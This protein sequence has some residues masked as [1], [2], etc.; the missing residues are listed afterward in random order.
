MARVYHLDCG[1]MRPR[2]APLV[3]GHGR[4][5]DPGQLVCHVMLVEGN[6]ELVLIDTGI[7]T[8][9]IEDPARLGRG[10]RML[11]RPTL[12]PSMTA[13]HQV[14]RLGYSPADVGHI[15][16]T[17]LDLDHAGG[18][19]DFPRAK[20]HVYDI[21]HDAAMRPDSLSER[22]RYRPV[23]FEHGVDWVR[24]QTIGERW[25]G[26]SGVRLVIDREAEIL[27]VPLLGHSRGHAGVAVHDGDGW[28]LHCGDAYFNRREICTH[29]RVG[30]LGLALVRNAAAVDNT[31]RRRNVARLRTL[32]QQARDVRLFSAHDPVELDRAQGTS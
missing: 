15:V 14:A 26:F 27:L 28:Q 8:R 12:D 29:H 9:D 1:P 10:F 3:D 7:G 25:Y 21:E 17:H 22:L 6:R 2:P 20:V 19:A 4:W 32:H 23:Q 16:L 5:R 30:P 31:V 13:L 18:L 11:A 24:H